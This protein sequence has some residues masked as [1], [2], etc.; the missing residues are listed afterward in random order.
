[1]ACENN[2]FIQFDNVLKKDCFL[3]VLQESDKLFQSLV[4]L[5][6]TKKDCYGTDSDVYLEYITFDICENN[7]INLIFHTNE[8]PC[9]PFCIK[10][11]VIYNVNIELLYFN[12]N[13][14][15]SGKFCVYLQQITINEMYTYW[16]GLY[17]LHLDLFWDSIPLLLEMYQGE[18]FPQFLQNKNIK[19][20]EKHFMEV[21]YRFD[22][23][24]LF[25]EFSKKF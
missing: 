14:D 9:I 25:K 22:E 5:N 6:G 24:L 21:K 20:S 4:P 18:T 13:N 10:L 3:K 16:Q 12:E 8:Y 1:M 15:Y 23:M 7:I 11:C 19:L 17:T 2:L